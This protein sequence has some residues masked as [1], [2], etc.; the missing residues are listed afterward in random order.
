MDV[1]YKNRVWR[2]LRTE[3]YVRKD[4]TKVVLRVYESP[5]AKCGAPFTVAVSENMGTDNTRFMLVHC[6]A[7]RLSRSEACARGRKAIKE[8]WKDVRSGK[9]ERPQMPYAKVTPEMRAEIRA[10]ASQGL[11]PHDLV[12]VYDLSISTLYN[13]IKA[14]RR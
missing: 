13:V 11:K 14:D 4:G 7:H 3:P 2:F 5:C 6:E 12:L 1:T 9:R 10:Y 8:Y